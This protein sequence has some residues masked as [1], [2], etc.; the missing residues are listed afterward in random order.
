MLMHEALSLRQI[1]TTVGNL[2][3]VTIP[4]KAEKHSKTEFSTSLPVQNDINQHNTMHTRYF[5]FV[6]FR[7]HARLYNAVYSYLLR[8]GEAF[9]TLVLMN[10]KEVKTN[11]QIVQ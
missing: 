11:S 7:A 4:K 6:S 3:F 2:K 9:R 5:D 10:I 8:F 1:L